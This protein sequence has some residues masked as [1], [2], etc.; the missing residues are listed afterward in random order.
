MALERC[1][2][3][4]LAQRSHHSLSDKLEEAE[5]LSTA[6][7]SSRNSLREFGKRADGDGGAVGGEEVFADFEF[8][9]RQKRLPIL[10][11]EPKPAL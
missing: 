6:A 9:D 3:R 1:L 11:S 5:H 2:F 10:A 7:D 8:T 4:T